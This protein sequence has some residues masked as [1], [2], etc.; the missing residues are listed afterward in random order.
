MSWIEYASLGDNMPAAK[1]EEE[2][3]NQLKNHTIKEP[4]FPKHKSRL[5]SPP[6]NQPQQLSLFSSGNSQAANAS[7]ERKTHVLESSR[8]RVPDTLGRFL[9]PPHLTGR[10]NFYLRNKQVSAPPAPREFLEFCFIDLMV[11]VPFINS[12][13]QKFHVGWSNVLVQ[14]EEQCADV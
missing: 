8:R 9:V 14:C 5:Q 7:R 2:N 12:S 4:Q 6:T 11:L 3:R 13:Q 1:E 10:S